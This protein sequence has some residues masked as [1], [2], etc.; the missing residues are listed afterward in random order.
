MTAIVDRE[1]LEA[2]CA[3]ECVAPRIKPHTTSEIGS[4]LRTSKTIW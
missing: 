4:W 1:L 3:H 2:A